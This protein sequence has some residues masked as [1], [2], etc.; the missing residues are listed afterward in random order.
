MNIIE[1]NKKLFET[2]EKIESGEMDIKKAQAMVNVSN[3]ISSNAKL[4]LSAAKL[5]KNPAIT[6]QLLGSDNGSK[7]R[8]EDADMYELKTEFALSK[9]YNNASEAIG[10]MGVNAFNEAFKNWNY[11][12]E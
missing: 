12:K 10:K 11:E 4:M 1:L 2:L 7:R 8:L 3:A 6:N 5:A 9:G